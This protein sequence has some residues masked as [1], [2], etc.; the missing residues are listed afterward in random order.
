MS[1]DQ[2][3]QPMWTPTAE[4]VARANMTRFIG[5]A[6]R[7]TGRRVSDFASLYR[8]SIET[9]EEFWPLVWRFC[10]VVADS[11][12]G[13]QWDSVL[14]GRDRMAPPDDEAGPKWFSGAKLN[15]AENLLRFD[16]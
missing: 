5:E 14:V 12:D 4:Q 16:D 3:D 15:F 7:A 13:T 11:R 8:W 1:T 2:N 9:P 6:R 10:E